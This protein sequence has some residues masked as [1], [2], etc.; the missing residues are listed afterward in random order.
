MRIGIKCTARKTLL[1]SEYA[2]FNDKLLMTLSLDKT[3]CLWDH[4]S[5]KLKLKIATDSVPNI[6]ITLPSHKVVLA[7]TT[8]DLKVYTIK[9]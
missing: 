1:P 7:D 9:Q 5:K 4:S 3:W 8:A 6:A 2:K